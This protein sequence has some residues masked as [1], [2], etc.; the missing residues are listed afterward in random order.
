MST[1]INTLKIIATIM[2]F[3]C[4]CGIVCN[5]SFGFELSD[6]WQM[7]LK[8]PAWGGVF[9]FFTISGFLASKSY[10]S[11][12]N[13]KS[14][15]LY[16]LKKKFCN[17]YIPC[18]I[19]I[20]LAY[21][22]TDPNGKLT[23]LFLLKLLTCT[24]NG[25]GGG[26][27]YIGAS[28]YVFVLMWLYLL[29]PIFIKVLSYWDDRHR[30]KTFKGYFILI[31]GIAIFGCLYRITG[32]AL[33]LEWYSGIYANVIGNLDLFL[34]GMIAHRMTLCLPKS[35][36]KIKKLFIYGLMIIFVVFINI[37]SIF[38]YYGET[39]NPALIHVYKYFFPSIYLV[40]T[41]SMLIWSGEIDKEMNSSDKYKR[42]TELIVPYTFMFYL[43]HSIIFSN[44]ADKIYLEDGLA[45]YLV[46]LSV[47]TLVTGY[48]SVLMTIMN[49]GINK[50]FMNGK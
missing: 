43:W 50:F 5:N 19:F 23:W 7:M 38:Y 39:N 42:V 31:A 24:F 47:G 35:F 16:F 2:V 25:T 40:L 10:S 49:K 9:I 26:I 48:V 33:G 29:T 21:I 17:I 36:Q 46:T 8:T 4:H 15:G 37:N 44:I 34:S 45:H 27:K 41:C 18:I 32:R 3:V 30:E 14:N 28:W 1:T 13:G 6:N 22:L 12:I 11:C 20:S